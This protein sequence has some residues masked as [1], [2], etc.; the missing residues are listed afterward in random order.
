M[1][2]VR[3]VIDAKLDKE[4]KPLIRAI[5]NKEYP[6]FKSEGDFSYR[7]LQLRDWNFQGQGRREDILYPQEMPIK[8]RWLWRG[9]VRA[10]LHVIFVHNVVTDYILPF[11]LAGGVL[12]Y[13]FVWD[14][15]F[16]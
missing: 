8:Q 13:Y 12:L 9:I 6:D 7:L 3:S 1:A 4:C 11:L 10:Y 5:V 15:V 16:I 2:S 14:A